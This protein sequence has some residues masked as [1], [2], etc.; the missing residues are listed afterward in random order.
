[1][2]KKRDGENRS[3][4]SDVVNLL[5]IPCR[6]CSE[7]GMV[8]ITCAPLLFDRRTCLVLLSFPW[9]ARAG[10]VLG[11]HAL[12]VKRVRRLS[13]FEHVLCQVASFALR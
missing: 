11:I 8:V 9:S 13:I 10:I 4:L 12:L 6:V 2:T 1:M 7:A 5:I 3:N